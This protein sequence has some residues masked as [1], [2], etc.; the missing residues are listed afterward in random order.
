MLFRSP[1][2]RFFGSHIDRAS[3]H[4]PSP[5]VATRSQLCTRRLQKRMQSRLY[6]A[7]SVHCSGSSSL[8]TTAS[9]LEQRS[10]HISVSKKSWSSD[11]PPPLENGFPDLSDCDQRDDLWSSSIVKASPGRPPTAESEVQGP[12]SSTLQNFLLQSNIR[13]QISTARSGAISRDAPA[14]AV[15]AAWSDTACR[16][17]VSA[18]PQQP[19]VVAAMSKERRV[20]FIG[21]AVPVQRS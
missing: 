10:S 19:V 1:Q 2:S 15:V 12:S 17:G 4:E 5:G 11:S 9:R 14:G 13:S 18:R 16:S 6:G 7:D 20:C 8:P 3:S 21:E